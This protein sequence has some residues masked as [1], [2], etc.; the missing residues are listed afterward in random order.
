L[1]LL[2]VDPKRVELTAYNDIPHLVAP[3]IV[4]AP[5]VVNAL[6]WVVSEMDRRY[7][8]FQDRQVKNIAEFNRAHTAETLP[9]LVVVIDELADLMQVS[10]KQVEATIVRIAQLARATSSSPPSAPA[11]MS[12]PG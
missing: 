9:Y 11:P 12:S 2:L 7:K 3:V 1:R 6:K 5:K 8:L 4:D 10:G